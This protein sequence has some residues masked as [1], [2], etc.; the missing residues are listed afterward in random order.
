MSKPKE[1]LA[2][3]QI[4]CPSRSRRH[5]ICPTKQPEHTPGRPRLTDEAPRA[6]EV[7]SVAVFKGL[8]QNLRNEDADGGL[9]FTYS[10]RGR[11]ALRFLMAFAWT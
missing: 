2:G 5:G 3:V 11:I 9:A 8:N 7:A 10:W 1:V 6:G 4:D